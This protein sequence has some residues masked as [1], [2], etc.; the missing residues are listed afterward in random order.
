[1][2][3]PQLLTRCSRIIPSVSLKLQRSPGSTSLALEGGDGIH[4]GEGLSYIMAVGPSELHCQGDTLS[5]RDDMVFAPGFSSVSRVGS[6]FLPQKPLVPRRCP[7]PL[8]ASPTG[9]LPVV[10]PSRRGGWHPTP[11]GAANLEGDANRS[12][13]CHS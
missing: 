4:Q 13:H 6:G 1:V 2:S 10:V 11:Q 5:L 12:C 8:F 7:A 9:L 3:A